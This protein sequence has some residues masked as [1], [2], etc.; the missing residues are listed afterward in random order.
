MRFAFSTAGEILF[1]RGMLAEAGERLHG[2]GNRAFVLHGWN[3][4]R[5]R[6]LLDILDEQEI[7]WASLPMRGEPTVSAAQKAA[8]AARESDANFIIGFGG[9]SVMDAA[10]ATAAFMTND[11]DPYEYLEVVGKGHPLPN[12]PLPCVAIPTTA[13]TG[14]EV[15][16]NSVLKA[17]TQRVKVSLRSPL[18][19][20]RLV[21]VDPELT[22]GLPPE[23]TASTGLD[24]LTQLMEAYVSR[25]ATPLTDGL[26][27]EGLVRGARSL[28]R[29]YHQG[30]D[31]EA[32]EDMCLASLFSGLALANAG[33]GAVHGFAA[34]LGGVLD[35][36]HGMICAALLPAVMR[37]NLQALRERGHNSPALQRYQD[38][39]RILTGNAESTADHGVAWIAAL[40]RELSSPGLGSLGL[41]LEDIPAMVE[42]GAR[43][44]SMRGNPLDLTPGEL[45]QILRDSM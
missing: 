28:A 45:A 7:S 16:R 23:V 36:P 32:R 24:A 8:E 1:G 3:V 33:L 38:M 9:G 40:C 44:S 15:T 30:N 20:P 21:I 2:L 34:P 17:E 26:C 11:A 25:K 18:L 14:A 6:P 22:L 35:A 27:L 10:K 31:I 13:G 12:A 42:K 41:R 19:L 4:E 5:A 43:A 39:A 29:A 37:V